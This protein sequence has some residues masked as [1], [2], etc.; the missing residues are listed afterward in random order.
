MEVI[1]CQPGVFCFALTACTGE[2]AP[3]P[4][5]AHWFRVVGYEHSARSYGVGLV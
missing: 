5:G 2:N 3:V 1:G 4:D